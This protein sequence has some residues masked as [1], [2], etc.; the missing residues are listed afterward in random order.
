MTR[1]VAG[2]TSEL[3]P[4]FDLLPPGE[5]REAMRR[6][7]ALDFHAGFFETSLTLHYAP[8]SVHG[9]TE[10]PP[11]PPILP[12]API[13]MLAGLFRKMG[14]QAAA[15]DFGFI[16]SALGWYALR[17]YPGYTGRPHLASAKAGAIMAAVISE[18][19]ARYAADVFAGRARSPEPVLKWLAPVTLG[20][21][22]G[23][24][25]VN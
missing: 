3:N 13:A 4:A 9:H 10:V 8:D 5:E 16:S 23:S 19:G 17:P 1:L 21:R 18:Q 7:A 12:V 24:P 2:E 15:R 20:G 25:H 22:I 11:C 6:D 14:F